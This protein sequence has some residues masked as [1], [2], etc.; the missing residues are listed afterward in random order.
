M[1]EVYISRL[2]TRTKKVLAEKLKEKEKMTWLF[3]GDSI[4]HGAL[5]TKGYDGVAQIFENI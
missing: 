4:T 2:W 1:W 5:W 3:M